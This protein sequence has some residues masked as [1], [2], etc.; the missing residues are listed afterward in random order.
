MSNL[1]EEFVSK[2]SVVIP[3]YSQVQWLEEAVE[4]VLGQDYKELEI[5]VVND[6]SEEDVTSFLSKYGDKIIYE[7]TMNGGPAA[8]R[9]RGIEMA[10]GEYVAF[11]DSDDIW[12]PNKLSI[13]IAMMR[14]HAAVWS[15]S[16]YV[17]FGLGKTKKY[18]MTQN[19]EAELQKSFI[20]Y[21]ATPS[22]VIRK[23]YLD[24]HR[25]CR[26]NPALRYGEDSY[27]WL[28]I[29][30]NVPIL[31]IPE[32]LVKVRM[33]GGNAGKVARVQLRARSELWK[34]RK[35]NKEL[36]IDKFE[37]GML[38]V[39]ASELC[40]FGHWLVSAMTRIVKNEKAVEFFA[41][42]LFVVPWVLFKIERV[43][44]KGCKCNA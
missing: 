23:D 6:G 39:I 22:V 28:T 30:A 3:F 19:D 43:G 17:T 14:K 15:Y 38:F 37:I 42:V 31:A 27:M 20:P 33:R 41:K 36:L 35:Q 16:N 10:T 8:A 5:I 40:T 34:C 9:N 32:E 12:V 11:L 1:E 7:R 4:S 44:C 13:Q 2:V 21:I 24:E 26:F 29:S 18:I 25:E